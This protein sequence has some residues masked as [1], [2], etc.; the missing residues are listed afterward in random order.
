VEA[1][2]DRTVPAGFS[3]GSRFFPP[4]TPGPATHLQVIA[5]TDA[6]VGLPS[7]IRVVAL[8]AANRTATGYVGTIA[9]TTADPLASA[10]ANYTFTASDHGQHTFQ[11]TF[12][13]AGTPLVTAADT[14]TATI[15]GSA[16]ATVIAAPVATH[17]QV[18]GPSQASAGQQVSITVYAL[19][20][21]NHVV[22]NYVGTVHFT[23]S[24]AGFSL[25]DYTFTAADHGRHS[26]QAI[27][28]TTVGP[29]TVTATDTATATVT[30]TTTI[31][32]NAPGVATHLAVW[33]SPVARSGSVFNVYVAALDA[34]NK[35]VPTYTGTVHF[36]STDTAAT[37]V[38]LPADYTFTLADQGVKVFQVTLVTQGQQT[39]SV[40]DNGVPALVGS[41]TVY[42]SPLRWFGGFNGWDIANAFAGMFRHGF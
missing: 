33:S 4:P 17:F 16:T 26:F 42:V 19:D 23:S 6:K 11:I 15:T 35:V 5:P 34:S 25:A 24:D 12:G 20:A 29:Q 31:A 32:V 28:G 36:G 13:T 18:V 1:L 38:V 21:S 7:S 3:F 27:L 30:G 14:T 39:V 8:D 40:T 37:G 2:E 41:A 22:K 10:I 9:V